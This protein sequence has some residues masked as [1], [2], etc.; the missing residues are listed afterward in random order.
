MSRENEGWNM[1]KNA[2]FCLV[3]VICNELFKGNGVSAEAWSVAL[4]GTDK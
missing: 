1:T 4:T 2:Q 3:M